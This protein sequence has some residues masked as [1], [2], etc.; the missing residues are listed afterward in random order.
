MTVYGVSVPVVNKQ[1]LIEYKKAVARDTDL[2]D[3][4]FMIPSHNTVA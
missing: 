1:E 4:E 3:V 2:I